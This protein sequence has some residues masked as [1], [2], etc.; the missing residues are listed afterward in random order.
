MKWIGWCLLWLC[1]AGRVGAEGPIVKVGSKKFTESVVVGELLVHLAS[2]SGAEVTHHKELGGTRI[3][4]SL[5][6]VLPGGLSQG[7]DNF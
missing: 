2:S 5:D 7:I 6:V 4:W 1:I 3:L